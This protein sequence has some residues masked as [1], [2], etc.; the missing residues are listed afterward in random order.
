V[1]A[2]RRNRTRSV[3]IYNAK[4]I[5]LA[6]TWCSHLPSHN[7]LHISPMS[8]VDQ[9]APTQSWSCVLIFDCTEVPPDSDITLYCAAASCTFARCYDT[10]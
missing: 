1:L 9:I 7:T 5:L 6:K 10:L 8:L 2:R 4:A 3:L